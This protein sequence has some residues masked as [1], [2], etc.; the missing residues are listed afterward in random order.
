MAQ[1]TPNATTDRKG[2]GPLLLCLEKQRSQ[3]WRRLR[4][5]RAHHW[6]SCLHA[7]AEFVVQTHVY[8]LSMPYQ[9]AGCAQPNS[10]L[11]QSNSPIFRG[12]MRRHKE[13]QYFVPYQAE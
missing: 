8:F 12:A 2:R 3:H 7:F 1:A 10:Q 9:R 5:Q 13:G 6:T 4:I 11:T